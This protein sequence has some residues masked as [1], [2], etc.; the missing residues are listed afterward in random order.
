MSSLDPMS[1]D[2]LEEDIHWSFYNVSGIIRRM[3]RQIEDLESAVP[4]S[5][6]IAEVDEWL[7]DN[8]DE[9]EDLDEEYDALLHSSRGHDS[10]FAEHLGDTLAVL[11]RTASDWGVVNDPYWNLVVRLDSDDNN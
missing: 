7:M 10:C 4:A 11:K 6:T 1:T 2:V 8:L 3:K 5:A 9:I